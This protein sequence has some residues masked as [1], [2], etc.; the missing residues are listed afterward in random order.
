[1]YHLKRCRQQLKIQPCLQESWFQQ[2]LQSDTVYKM[3]WNA[4]PFPHRKDSLTPA[5]A[6]LCTKVKPPPQED[7]A[8][9]GTQGVGAK[10][11][12]SSR[13][14]CPWVGPRAF[15]CQQPVPSQKHFKRTWPGCCMQLRLHLQALVRPLMCQCTSLMAAQ[16]K[17]PKPT[18]Q[19]SKQTKQK[20]YFSLLFL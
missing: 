11:C 16:P 10:P 15:C 9:Q 12:A 13:L 3:H 1:M 4:L 7:G 20:C 17:N 6:M 2:R 19:A 18:N 14:L 5:A 8:A